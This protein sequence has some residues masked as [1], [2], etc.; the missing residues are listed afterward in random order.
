MVLVGVGP[1]G[2]I[3]NQLNLQNSTDGC[4]IQRVNEV[5]SAFNQRL[6]PLSISLNSSLPGSFFVYQN[7]YDTFFDIIQNPSNYG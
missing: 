1:L 3:P 5:V 4:C 2:C 6:V 7:I